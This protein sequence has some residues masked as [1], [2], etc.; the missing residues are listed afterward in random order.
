MYQIYQ[1]YLK[2]VTCAGE[3]QK[4]CGPLGLR[5]QSVLCGTGCPMQH[6][7]HWFLRRSAWIQPPQPR[8]HFLINL[9]SLINLVS[10]L[11]WL[12]L[13]NLLKTV[14]WA[15]K[16]QKGCSPLGLRNQLVLCG[17]RCPM[18]RST[19]WFLKRSAWIQSPQP[20]LYFF[21]KFNKFHKF[22]KFIKFITFIKFIRFI[23]K[24]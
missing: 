14:T 2:T 1:I 7:T 20:T 17:T 9:I 10:L 23:W 6:S 13:L 12:N 19:H 16:L 5:N 18:Q 22:S 3:L 8:L 4:G 24:I 21:Y 15:G 11:N